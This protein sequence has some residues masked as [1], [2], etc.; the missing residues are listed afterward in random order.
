MIAL[1][2]FDVILAYTDGFDD[3]VY[4]SDVPKCIERTIQNGVVT[5]LS[6]AADCLAI[7]A[8]LL[9]KD[10]EY[11]SPFNK[12]WKEAFD[13]GERLGTDPPEGYDFR[14]GKQDDITVVVA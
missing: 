7:K 1:D 6:E 3:N 8:N 5:S 4:N 12:L 2:D 10:P 14:G 13:K 9:S 11:L